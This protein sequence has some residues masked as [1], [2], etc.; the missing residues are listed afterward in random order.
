M[1][2]FA[3][4]IGRDMARVLA[5]CGG[6]VVAGGAT[7]GQAIVIEARVG[8]AAGGVAIVT[9]IATGHMANM[10]AGG[11]GAVMTTGAGAANGGMI[12]A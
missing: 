10:F 5:S 3:E 4:I 7:R 2:V 9:G 8:P 12:H 11:G 1:T 6:A